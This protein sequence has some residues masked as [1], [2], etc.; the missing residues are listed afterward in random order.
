MDNYSAFEF[1]VEYVLIWLI[2]GFTLFL[3]LTSLERLKRYYVQVF[4]WFGWGFT[5]LMVVLF[6]RLLLNPKLIYE[7]VADDPFILLVPVLT[8]II[9]IAIQKIFDKVKQKENQET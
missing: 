5:I 4:K 9:L 8:S 1:F 7:R 3:A 6:V 2:L